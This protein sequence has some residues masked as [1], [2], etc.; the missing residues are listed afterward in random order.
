MRARCITLPARL[1]L[2]TVIL[3]TPLFSHPGEIGQSRTIS[4]D[5]QFIPPGRYTLSLNGTWRQAPAQKSVRVPGV[6]PAGS[7]YRLTKKFHIPDSLRGKRFQ[8]LARGINQACTITINNTFVSSH[9]GGYTSFRTDIQPEVLQP[10]SENEI[11][12]EI[13]TDLTPKS[14]L[15]FRHRP[16][17]W[18][19]ASG[20]TGGISLEAL[21]AIA[22]EN[23]EFKQ[24]IDLKTDDDSLTVAV[25]LRISGSAEDT[26]GAGLSLHAEVRKAGDGRLLAAAEAGPALANAAA[27]AP[28]ALKIPRIKTWTPD[29]PTLYT[30]TLTLRANRQDIDSQQYT[31]GS[32]VIEIR[33]RQIFLNG[34]L[35]IVKGVDWYDDLAGLTG[36]ALDTAINATV[37]RLKKLGANTVRVVGQ[38]AHPRFV[39]RCSERGLFLLEEIPLYYANAA[40][41]SSPVVTDAALRALDETVLRDRL[42]P[43]VLAWGLGGYLEDNAP[44]APRTVAHLTSRV[45]SRD[46]RPVYFLTRTRGP[47]RSAGAVDFMLFDQLGRD[48]LQFDPQ[49][50]ADKPVIPVLGFF[51]E[52]ANL[53]TSVADPE[54][55]R[56]E[57]EEIQAANLKSTLQ[58]YLEE[59]PETAG[60]FVHALADW[61]ASAPTSLC[62]AD[63]D[64]SVIPGGLLKPTG[65]E[66][67][68]YRMVA[69]YY[70]TG[71]KPAISPMPVLPPNP[72]VFPVA[73]IAAVLSFLFF[74]NHNKKFRSQVRRSYVHPHGFYTDLLE[75]RKTPLFL[76]VFVGLIESVVVAGVASSVL[77]AYRDNRIFDELLGLFLPHAALKGYAIWLIWHPVWLI[78]FS[79]MLYF[80]CMIFLA[81]LLRFFSLFFRRR[82]KYYQFFTFVFWAAVN[83][84]PLAVVVPI[85]YRLLPS[86]EVLPI[87]L[88][89]SAIFLFWHFVRLQRGLRVLYMISPLR[90]LLLT[91][92]LFA[93]VA[94]TTVFYLNHEYAF[95]DYYNYYKSLIS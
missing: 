47:N 61:R 4:S 29:S 86:P 15:P 3:S 2:I 34:E 55:W 64:L 68:G 67:I 7:K 94:G 21:P 13:S 72:I 62:G 33:G 46:D 35:F 80:F 54:R 75:R 44:A 71:R 37:D 79:S 89:G 60:A 40:Q 43:A 76:T 48:G 93:A 73:G 24:K 81:F 45:R 51:A 49:W 56:I 12:I 27:P 17:G 53:R 88:V 16:Y 77:C 58:L 91:L 57:S 8:L 30:L 10:G 83:Y 95:L 23:I 82:I 78:T 22:I 65:A 11:A 63:R 85:L 18:P 66:R 70:G 26:V 41:L 92:L 69:S 74:M 28:L 90:A 36:A 5:W 87:V 52:L 39:Q 38:P 42:Q 31:F 84:L 25:K 14:T 9:T 6:L 50:F 32:R 59:M 19:N 20:I 1:F